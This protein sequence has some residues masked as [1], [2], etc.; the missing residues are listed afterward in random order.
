ME[1]PDD[2]VTRMVAEWGE[3]Q[4]FVGPWMAIYKSGKYAYGS[5]LAEFIDSHGV[6]NERENGYVKTEPIMAYRYSGPTAVVVTI[7]AD[8]T[9]ETK[10]TVED[11]KWMVR[12]KKGEVGVMEDATFRRKYIVD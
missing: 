6:S 1:A 2:F 8:G 9:V 10:N 12:W 11:G 4:T 3:E 7:L 5:A